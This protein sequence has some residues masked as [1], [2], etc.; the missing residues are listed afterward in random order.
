[1]LQGQGQLMSFRTDQKVMSNCK[2]AKQVALQIF[3][4]LISA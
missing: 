1:M 4:G 2:T 3:L